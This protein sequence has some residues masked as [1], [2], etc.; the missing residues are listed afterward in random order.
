MRFLI[1]LQGQQPD[2]GRLENVLLDAD[3]AALLDMDCSGTALRVSTWIADAELLALMHQAG[4]RLRP[5][6]LERLPSE[7]C[8]GCGG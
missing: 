5:E 8:G 3:P 6:Q 2:L 7:C 1:D 4:L